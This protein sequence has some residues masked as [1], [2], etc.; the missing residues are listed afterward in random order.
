[1]SFEYE[2]DNRGV[3]TDEGMLEARE[4]E[5][6][7]RCGNQRSSHFSEPPSDAVDRLFNRYDALTEV[8]RPRG[9][10]AKLRNR[11]HVLR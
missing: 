5:V 10:N 6:S 7:P 1:M 8:K 9:K 4:A 2:L 11:F 3:E